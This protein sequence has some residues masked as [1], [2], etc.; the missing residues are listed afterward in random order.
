MDSKEILR[1]VNNHASRKVKI[2]LTDI[3]GVLRGKYISV[4][5][6]L[7]VVEYR[8][9]ASVMS[10]SDGMLPMLPTTTYLIRA[11]T[12]VIP[13]QLPVWTCQPSEKFPGKTIFPF[14]W[15]N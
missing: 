5:K 14:F 7:S 10:F 6:F 11:G 13:M 12:L 4:E 8:I 1:Y 2:A 3:D 15:V 9:R